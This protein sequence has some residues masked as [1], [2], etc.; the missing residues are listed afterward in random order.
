MCTPLSNVTL[1]FLPSA[2][3]VTSESSLDFEVSRR[4]REPVPQDCCH[5][6]LDISLTY[7]PLHTYLFFLVVKP[8]YIFYWNILPANTGRFESNSV[9]WFYPELLYA[10]LFTY[11]VKGNLSLS[12]C[13]KNTMSSLAKTNKQRNNNQNPTLELALIFSVWHNVGERLAVRVSHCIWIL[14]Y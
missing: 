3:G 10:I 13:S 6:S 2:V 14:K 1:Q 8:H 12:L 4:S 7:L 9:P 11:T 5:S